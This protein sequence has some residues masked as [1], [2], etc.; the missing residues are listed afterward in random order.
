MPLVR[1]ITEHELNLITGAIEPT[2][3]DLLEYGFDGADWARRARAIFT[4]AMEDDL[5]PEERV[6]RALAWAEFQQDRGEARVQAYRACTGAIWAGIASGEIR[7]PFRESVT[8]RRPIGR[9]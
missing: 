2:A 9:G 1:E 5:E 4:H 3:D 6:M 7:N 8:F